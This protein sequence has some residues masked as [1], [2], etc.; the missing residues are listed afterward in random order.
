M[1]SLDA[2]TARLPDDHAELAKK[3]SAL[4]AALDAID[5]KAMLCA[6]LQGRPFR[7]RFV[8]FEVRIYRVYVA[9]FLS[10]YCRPRADARRS[11][12]T[13]PPTLFSVIRVP[14]RPVDLRAR[15]PRV[16]GRA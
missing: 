2:A 13:R 15:C 5:H 3:A 1:V 9:I 14:M 10:G 12:Q 16:G 8:V 4:V 6:A 11:G 7:V